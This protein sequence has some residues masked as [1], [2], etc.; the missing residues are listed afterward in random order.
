MIGIVLPDESALTD[1]LGAIKT[2]VLLLSTFLF[3][4]TL[5]CYGFIVVAVPSFR[6]LYAGFGESLPLLTTVV[7][8]YAQFAI[9]LAFIGVAPI[10]SMWSNRSSE[11]N[12]ARGA[13][14]KIL[15]CFGISQGVGGIVV[16]GLYLPL[17]EMGAMAS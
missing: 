16:A 4:W 5:I 10:V 9:V 13:F 14:K 2:W 11:A 7:I 3:V 6:E 15:I 17:F 8:S 12:D 1:D